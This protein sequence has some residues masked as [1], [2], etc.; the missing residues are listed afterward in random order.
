MITLDLEVQNKTIPNTSLYVIIPEITPY[1]VTM[2][3]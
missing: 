1:N 3:I 2:T